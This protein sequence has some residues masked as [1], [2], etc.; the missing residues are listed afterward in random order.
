MRYLRGQV[1]QNRI[2]IKVGIKAFNPATS[3]L[4]PQ[5]LRFEEFTALVDTGALR[6]CVTQNVVD[7][8]SLKRRG[9]IEVG[10]VRNRAW[11]WTYLFH[12]AI[13]PDTE[14]GSIAA[15]FGIG[16]EVEGID[17]G[18]SRY[19][20]VLLGMDILRRGTLKLE[21]DG[22]FELAFPG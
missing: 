10:N 12:V 13:W 14:D 21:L 7:R 1:R 8:L 6:T 19:Y 2:R 9:R 5:D 16:D 15:A 3:P 20:D 22:G 18:D 17:V 4:E 11:H